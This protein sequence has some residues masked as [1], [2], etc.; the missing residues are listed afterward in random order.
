MLL[1]EQYVGKALALADYVVLLARGRVQ[2]VGEPQ[3][4]TRK[5]SAPPTR[6]WSHRRSVL[7]PRSTAMKRRPSGPL[8]SSAG[9]VV[10]SGCAAGS[11][12]LR[13]SPPSRAPRPPRESYATRRRPLRD[14]GR[15][16]VPTPAQPSP[17]L[18][19]RP[20]GPRPPPARPGPPPAPA[21][22]VRRRGAA[23]STSGSDRAKGN[24]G[25]Y[26]RR[27]QEHGEGQRPADNIGFVGSITGLYEVVPSGA[28]RR[29][30]QPDQPELP[31]RHQRPP[32][33]ADRRDTPVTRRRT[34]PRSG[35]W[36]RSTRSSRSSEHPRRLALAGR[37]RLRRVQA[38]PDPRRR[39]LEP[40][41]ADEPH[42]LRLSSAG[43]A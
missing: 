5:R 8:R 18:R 21:R 20:A 14:Q 19:P 37:D 24:T 36:S 1:V 17:V 43:S 10:I 33:E 13:S 39:R 12:V 29:A 2:F 27:D 23:G 9:L 16:P 30:G 6:A 28:D 32:G 3:S 25:G 34:W 22:P 15:R 7:S 40:A 26:R 11:T 31:R 4:S 42:D 35:G 38:D 41:R